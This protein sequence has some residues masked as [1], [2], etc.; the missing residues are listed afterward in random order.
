MNKDSAN[1]AKTCIDC[2]KAKITR[3]TRSE[4]QRF[5]LS[6][7]RFQKIHIDLVGPL[8]PS[9]GYVYIFTI[10]GRFTRWT[11][12]IPLRDST[13]STVA[14]ALVSNYIARFGV[15]LELTSDQGSQFESLLFQELTKLLG[16]HKIRTTPYHPQSNGIIERFNRNLKE[17]LIARGNTDNWSEELPLVLLGV[18]TAFKEDMS[19][20][21]AELVY[22]QTLK[23]PGDF[24]VA[25]NKNIQLD[26][27]SYVEHLRN[28]MQDLIPKETRYNK[29]NNIYI[30]KDLETCE[31]VFVRVDK[32]RPSL[33]APYDGPFKVL[34]RLR[35]HYVID[36]KNKNCSISIDRLKPAY[37]IESFS[38]NL[39]LLTS[40][41]KRDQG[42]LKT[43]RFQ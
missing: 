7:A 5:E 25:S 10:I 29:Q 11:E 36:I 26:P 43:I 8:R 9:N 17:I 23:I 16:I 42:T 31:Y 35:K 18:R 27:S 39:N 13:A 4:F 41:N 40:K 34:K 28:Y 3:H 30:P 1:W 38:E 15:P 12:A 22:G 24:F 37:G 2:Q 33:T 21:P 19:C 14:E 32:I 6:S 20:T